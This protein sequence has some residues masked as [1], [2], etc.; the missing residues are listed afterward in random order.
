ML[1]NASHKFT[2][3]LLP[4]SQEQIFYCP[5]YFGMTVDEV[6]EHPTCPGFLK[7]TLR[8]FPW[9]GRCN[10]LQ[11]RPQDFRYRMPVLLGNGWHVDCNVRLKD[12]KIR[13]AR[14][15]D[16]WKI[17]GVSFGDV[18]QTIFIET[19]LDLPELSVPQQDDHGKFFFEILPAQKFT[20]HAPAECQLAEY[21]TRDI[22]SIGKNFNMG[23]MR[24][25]ILGV[26]SDDYAGGG[27]QLPS[28]WERENGNAPKFEEYNL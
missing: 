16:D 4:L 26:E 10:S 20:Y 14:H 21:T 17:M 18:V 25:L 15:I 3:H 12:G 27:M 8:E 19:V 1:Y 9:S 5:E 23:R 22:H 2:K 13:T 24:L 7:E 28:I 11:I 6:C